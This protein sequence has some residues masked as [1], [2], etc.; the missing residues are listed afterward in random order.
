MEDNIIIDNLISLLNNDEVM[1]K[2]GSILLLGNIKNKLASDALIE[3]VNKEKN[4]FIRKMIIYTLGQT[5]NQEAI[6]VLE[7]I[8][9][10]DPKNN[11]HIYSEIALCSLEEKKYK[12]IK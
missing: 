10:N 7:K 5:K 6:S 11:T 9:N 8:S 12:E 3:A 4:V 1:V 2:Y